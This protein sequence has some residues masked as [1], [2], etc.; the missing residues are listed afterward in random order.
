MCVFVCVL[1]V[2]YTTRVILRRSVQQ[3]TIVHKTQ[4]EISP[5]KF[6]ASKWEQQQQ[7]QQQ[8]QDLNLVHLHFQVNRN[9]RF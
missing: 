6:Q 8:Q 9:F 5:E 3:I 4:Q 7:Q 2:S 1:L